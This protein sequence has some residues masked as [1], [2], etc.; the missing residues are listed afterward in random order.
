MIF[1][2]KMTISVNL[3]VLSN[4]VFLSTRGRE[5]RSAIPPI[6]QPVSADG[7]AVWKG[8]VTPER[9]TAAVTQ[10]RYLSIEFDVSLRR[11][12]GISGRDFIRDNKCGISVPAAWPRP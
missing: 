1:I 7:T 4:I 2:A 11:V 3:F 5:T 6:G 9:Y 8:E 10:G 12:R